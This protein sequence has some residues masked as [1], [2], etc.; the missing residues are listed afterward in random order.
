[1]FIFTVLDI[2]DHGAGL[3]A[4]QV[5]RGVGTDC[6]TGVVSCFAGVDG[7][8]RIL[9]MV[10]SIASVLF[11]PSGGFMTLIESCKPTTPLALMVND[12]YSPSNVMVEGSGCSQT[13]R[14]PGAGVAVGDEVASGTGVA[15][16]AGVAVATGV[17]V[18]VAVGTGVGVPVGAVSESIPATVRVKLPVAPRE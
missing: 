14:D 18:V 8:W 15:V 7:I 2:D 11:G 1:M 9:R 17:G 13:F 3:A 10:L 12:F 16:G 4:D 6:I 5:E